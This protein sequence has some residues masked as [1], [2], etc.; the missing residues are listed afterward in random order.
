MKGRDVDPKRVEEDLSR[1]DPE[2]CVLVIA[3]KPKAADKIAFSLSNNPKV[4][5]INGVRVYRVVWNGKTMIIAPTAGHL[6]SL[7]TKKRSYPVFEYEW[8]P[9]HQ[10]EKGYGHLRKYYKVLQMLA[11]KCSAYVNA[12]DYDV[13]G[14]LIGYMIISKFG[15][16]N[17]ALRAKFSSLTPQEIRR[18]FSNLVQ[19]DRNMVEAGYCRHVLDWL[20]GINFSRLLMDIHSRALNE[21][22][23]LSVGRVQTPTLIYAFQRDIER[24]SFVPRPQYSVS[25]RVVVCG[26]KFR[27]DPEFEPFESP[28]AARK[29]VEEIKNR[30]TLAPS[31]REFLS[32]EVEPPYPF[33]LPD[34]QYEAYRVLKLTPAKTLKLAEDLYLEGLISYPRTNSQKIPASVNIAEIVEGLSRNPQY[35]QLVRLLLSETKGVLKPN[36]GPK[37]D[38]AH[39]AIHPTGEVPLGK[40]SLT[41]MHLKLYDLI[42]RRF[43]ATL[44]NSLKYSVAVLKFPIGGFTFSLT[45]K[46]LERRGWLLYYP[47]YGYDFH[48]PK[49]LEELKYIRSLPISE[50][51]V[52]KSF[53]RS[54]QSIKRIDLLKWMESAGIGT[55]ATR[56]EIIETLYKRGYIRSASGAA[57]VSDLGITVTLFITKY[58]PELASVELT[59]K[60]EEMLN[61]IIERRI[62]CDEVLKKAENHIASLFRG[63]TENFGQLVEDYKALSSAEGNTRCKV[64]NRSVYRDGLCRLHYEAYRNLV[65]TYKYWKASGF[66][67]GDYLKKVCSMKSTGSLVKE[68]CKALE[69]GVQ[70]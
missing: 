66:T 9:R 2:S 7:H 19:L 55:E 40:R 44:S 62:S 42:V 22:L 15:D 67:W 27:L 63:I 69:A 28:D 26:S 46:A 68:V 58:I 39:P 50:V 60:F 65:D 37:D 24:R 29:L 14:S 30:K 35:S 4:L 34:L 16:V 36:N 5:R 13:E 3:E 10:V 21:R 32:R 20:W 25:V 38:P 64:C 54:P 61:S 8:M 12:C 6:F 45:V 33:N 59:R 56:A 47:F 17:R 18:A 43:L 31:K 57:Y 70:I 49:C 41:K 23:V 53:T 11:K 52:V 1:L 51:K 48:S